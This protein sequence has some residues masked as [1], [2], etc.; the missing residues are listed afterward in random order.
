MAWRKIQ[1]LYNICKIG[2]CRSLPTFLVRFHWLFKRLKTFSALGFS[3]KPF[4]P[5]GIQN[6]SKEHSI[7]QR[8]KRYQTT[9][10]KRGGKERRAREFGESNCVINKKLRENK[11]AYLLSYYGSLQPSKGKTLAM[12]N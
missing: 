7:I 1:E 4:M 3:L 12:Q 10:T 6:N 9:L 2:L 8:G 5:S 11:A